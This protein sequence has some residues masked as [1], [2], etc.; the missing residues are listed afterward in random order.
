MSLTHLSRIT[1][2]VD[3]IHIGVPKKD[4]TWWNWES[5]FKT[6][7][8]LDKDLNTPFEKLPL[9]P[10]MKRH[11]R[12]EKRT[13]KALQYQMN[14]IVNLYK[15]IKKNGYS[16]DKPKYIWGRILGNGIVEVCDG[17]HRVSMLKY[18]GKPKKFKMEIRTRHPQW[19]ELKQKA[20]GLYKKKKL[21]QP[22]EHPDFADWKVDRECIDRWKSIKAYLGDTPGKSFLDI[23]SC[24]GWFCWQLARAGA[25]VI[26]V[27]KNQRRIQIARTLSKYHRFPDDNPQFLVGKFEDHIKGQFDGVLFLSVFHHYIRLHKEEAWKTTDLISKHSKMMFMDLSL[28]RLPLEWNPQKVLDTSRFTKVKQLSEGNRPLYVFSR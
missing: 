21:Y 16:D 27:D 25:K 18:W 14:R 9:Y 17:H 19:L 8:M 13:G 11:F 10:V 23:G 7:R 15:E 28:N 12:Q 22:L 4:Q 20:Y 24:T 3:D 2:D 5:Y 1:V 26:G 6:W